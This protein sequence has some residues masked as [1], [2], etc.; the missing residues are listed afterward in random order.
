MVKKE[1]FQ[2][3][4]ERVDEICSKAHELGISVFIDA[5]ESWIQDPIDEMVMQM[6]EKYNKEKATVFNTYQLYNVHKLGHM[7]RDHQRCQ[8]KGVFFG[9]KMVR[10]AYMDKERARAEEK[11]YPS[12]IHIDKVATDNDYND[13]LRYCIDNYETISSLLCLTQCRKQY[14]S[15]PLDT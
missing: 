5:E 12:P 10:G 15:G 13:A 4:Y 9:S 1:N 7:K 14:V 2:H 11:A 8:N 6:M 3:L